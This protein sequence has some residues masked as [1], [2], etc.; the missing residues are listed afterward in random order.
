MAL[1]SLLSHRQT[2]WQ[3]FDTGGIEHSVVDV[4][5]FFPQ[6]YRS[7]GMHPLGCQ[8]DCAEQTSFKQQLNN[9]S[10]E[11]EAYQLSYHQN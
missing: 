6:K 7:D 1:A 2:Q 5:L 10:A 9:L 4:A 11:D 3:Y 8:F